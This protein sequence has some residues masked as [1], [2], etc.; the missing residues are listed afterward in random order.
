MNFFEPGR[1]LISGCVE[2]ALLGASKQPGQGSDSPADEADIKEADEP[3][4][5][6]KASEMPPNLG[7]NSIH[8]FGTSP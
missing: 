6:P 3:S 5:A 8:C 4:L 1:R 2:C 7:R